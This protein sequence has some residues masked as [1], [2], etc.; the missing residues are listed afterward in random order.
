M[1]ADDTTYKP[2]IYNT[3]VVQGDDFLPRSFVFSDESGDVI[4]ITNADPEIL[5]KTNAGAVA[6]TYT[7]DHGLSIGPVDLGDPEPVI[8][9]TWSI[10]HDETEQITPGV[11]RMSLR[12]TIE[13]I[14][15]TYVTGTFVVEG[16]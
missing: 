12:L 7:L 13:G 14:R 6:K 10:D 8:A 16:V 11:L 4:D 9:L 15:R 5:L 1:S 3:G 2:S